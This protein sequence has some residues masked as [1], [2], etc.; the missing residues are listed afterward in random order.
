MQQYMLLEQGGSGSI[1]MFLDH[2]FAQLSLLLTKAAIGTH[3]PDMAAWRI[4][5][6]K[7][8]VFPRIPGCSFTVS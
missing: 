8:S 3:I 5:S 7:K 4:Y 1:E 2:S 6:K